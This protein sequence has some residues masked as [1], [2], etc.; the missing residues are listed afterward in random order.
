RLADALA[1]FQR[2]LQH[3]P[4]SVD[5][6][7]NVGNALRDQGQFDDA[8]ESYRR[9][10]QINPNLAQ[11]QSN[12]LLSLQNRPTVTLA[13][14][15]AAH[16]QYERTFAAPLRQT[17]RPHENSRDPDRRL[18]L[19]V[20]SPHLARH[21]VGYFTIGFVERLDRGQVE[22]V[23]YSDRVRDDDL[24]ARFRVAAATWRPVFG[25]TDERLARRHLSR[26]DVRRPAFAQPPLERRPD[27]DDRRRPGSLRRVGGR[28]GK[29]PASAGGVTGRAAGARGVVAA[30][31]PES[32]RRPPAAV[33]PRG[34]AR[35]GS[36][37]R[38][39]VILVR[40]LSQG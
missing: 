6:L 13:Q 25:W 18:R 32:V 4:N 8:D 22:V 7:N 21:P 38:R 15:A 24:T 37:G 11:V 33:A 10:L 19:G 40:A 17:W 27:R 29:R 31:R 2:A 5:A 9:A 39:L 16:A 30:V 28:S 23:C 26:R 35:M 1:S 34:V 20:V 36:A 12:L 14:L 3:D